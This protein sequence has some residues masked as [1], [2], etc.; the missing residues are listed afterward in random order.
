MLLPSPL[1]RK[2]RSLLLPHRCHPDHSRCPGPPLAHD[3]HP[4]PLP[5]VLLP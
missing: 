4:F 3:K 1:F 5:G 2:H